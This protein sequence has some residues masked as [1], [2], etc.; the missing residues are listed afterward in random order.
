MSE[1]VTKSVKEEQKLET[2]AEVKRLAGLTIF[3]IVVTVLALLFL[4]AV[5]A[6][7]KYSLIS[8]SGIAFSDF[9]GYTSRG[10]I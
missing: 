4:V 5:H 9:R 6:Q 3:V 10:V 1:F 2:R 7:D 8:P